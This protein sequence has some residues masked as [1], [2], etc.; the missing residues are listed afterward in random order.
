MKSK[1][2]VVAKV[3]QQQ[4]DMPMQHEITKRH[5][6]DATC[7]YLFEF[8]AVTNYNFFFCFHSFASSSKCTNVNRTIFSVAFAVILFIS[9][10]QSFIFFFFLFRLFLFNEKELSASYFFRCFPYIKRHHNNET[11][12]IVFDRKIEKNSF[13]IPCM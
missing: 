3:Y 2:K 5:T 4:I 10:V 6:L 7:L 9:F 12:M 8:K 1:K 13:L 11:M